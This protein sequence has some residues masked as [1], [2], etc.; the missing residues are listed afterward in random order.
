MDRYGPNKTIKITSIYNLKNGAHAYAMSPSNS[1]VC[2]KQENT[3]YYTRGRD[4]VC[5][6]R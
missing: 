3:Q 6:A 2:I 4:G 5:R 1:V